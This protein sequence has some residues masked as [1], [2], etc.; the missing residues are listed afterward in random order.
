MPL[1][2][3]SA[4][5]TG[6][7]GVRLAGDAIV[8]VWQGQ[9]TV[10]GDIDGARQALELLAERLTRWFGEL[11]S[12]LVDRSRPP[13]PL[14]HDLP[15]EQRLADAVAEKVGDG[16]MDA[17]TAIR[18]LWTADYLDVVRRLQGAIVGPVHALRASGPPR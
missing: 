11:G 6:V 17:A 9:D 16:S 1:A 4:L 2:E 8:D 15:L 3:V 14:H 5:V 12:D 10:H 13:E 7:A 18:V